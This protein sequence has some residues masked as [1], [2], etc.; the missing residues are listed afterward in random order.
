MFTFR[1][2]PDLTLA[3][4]HHDGD[5]SVL[6]IDHALALSPNS[7]RTIYK[8][9]R[10]RTRR[11]LNMV[12]KQVIGGLFSGY[13]TGWSE[14]ETKVID[15][16]VFLANDVYHP[17]EK[18]SRNFNK[19]QADELWTATKDIV[20]LLRDTLDADVS[21]HLRRLA[22]RLFDP[23]FKIQWSQYRNNCQI[24]CDK[25]L[26]GNHYSTVFPLKHPGSDLSGCLP[27]YL[28][29]FVARL[30]HTVSDRGVAKSRPSALYFGHFHRSEDIIDDMLQ[31]DP[32]L[33]LRNERMLL[34][35]CQAVHGQDTCK[36]VDHVWK[37]PSEAASIL[38]FH[39]LRSSALYPVGNDNVRTTF[40][41]WARNRLEVVNALDMLVT[42]LAAIRSGFEAVYARN[43]ADQL[44]AP[45][46]AKELGRAGGVLG[47]GEEQ[48]MVE[49]DKVDFAPEI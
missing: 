27:R 7:P 43:R 21:S 49:W 30:P 44:W 4:G 22:E 24:F 41:I 1:D 46:G 48:L 14:M 34:W 47:D 26:N 38:Q 13:E 36:L 2:P 28:V 5:V 12:V 32:A 25:L 37:F 45:P 29:S 9:R 10:R 20:K 8:Q 40:H 11:R 3:A 39:L 17:D 15:N 16:L 33:Q 31:A 19:R 23:H 18:K 42:L 35:R 6:H